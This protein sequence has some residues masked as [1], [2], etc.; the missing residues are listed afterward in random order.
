MQ[1]CSLQA[2]LGTSNTA[3]EC[4]YV[5]SRVPQIRFTSATIYRSVMKERRSAAVKCQFFE[6]HQCLDSFALV[7][8]NWCTLSPTSICPD[9]DKRLRPFPQNLLSWSSASPVPCVATENH[10]Q[11]AFDPVSAKQGLLISKVHLHMSQPCTNKV[12]Q[13]TKQ[14]ENLI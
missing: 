10:P 1:I 2:I 13:N 6:L 4:L 7:P 14:D 9:V 8:G 3:G 11:S 12:V 5:P